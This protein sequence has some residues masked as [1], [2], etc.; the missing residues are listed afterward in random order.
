MAKHGRVYT[1]HFT[2]YMLEISNFCEREHEYKWT[3]CV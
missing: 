2:R 3:R 1:L